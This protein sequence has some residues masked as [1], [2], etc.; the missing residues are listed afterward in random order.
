MAAVKKLSGAAMAL[1][2]ASLLMSG[3]VAAHEGEGH[4]EAKFKCAGINGCKGQTSCK[5]A[6]NDCKGKN[7]CKGKGWKETASKEDCVAQKGHQLEEPKKD[8]AKKG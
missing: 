3:A 6:S 1:A 4:T 7:S 2:A 8:D 5:S